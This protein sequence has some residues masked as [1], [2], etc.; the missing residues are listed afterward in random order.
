MK[1][2]FTPNH[3]RRRKVR[4][5]GKVVGLIEHVTPTHLW[6]DYTDTL[7]SSVRWLPVGVDPHIPGPHTPTDAALLLALEGN[8][9]RKSIKALYGKAA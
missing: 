2:A 4:V 6:R 5:K 1:V 7:R 3:G 9:A 8:D